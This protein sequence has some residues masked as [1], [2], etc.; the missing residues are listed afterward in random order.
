MSQKKTWTLHLP[1]LA[2]PLPARVAFLPDLLVRPV[3]LLQPSR[4]QAGELDEPG[5]LGVGIEVVHPVHD[6]DLLILDRLAVGVVDD[7]IVLIGPVVVVYSGVAPGREV[8]PA[9]AEGEGDARA[10]VEMGGE[11]DVH[12]GPRGHRGTLPALDDLRL[13]RLEGLGAGQQR[14]CL[15]AK[16]VA[17]RH[18][19]P[20]LGGVAFDRRRQLL[21][22]RDLTAP[23]QFRLPLVHP[24]DPGEMVGLLGLLAAKAED[25]GKAG[26]SGR[27]AMR[28]RAGPGRGRGAVVHSKNCRT[29][30]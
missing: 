26:I 9:R 22:R 27:R 21:R 14:G 12:P 5:P 4:D 6:E 30:T 10:G 2:V 28:R 18:G 15:G 29:W 23:K 25:T 19:G 20:P 16:L 17:G 11:V 13:T 8:H 7:L 3:G 24:R 1:E